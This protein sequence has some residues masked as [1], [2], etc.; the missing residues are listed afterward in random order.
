MTYGAGNKCKLLLL[1]GKGA[2]TL[3]LVGG[4]DR[5]LAVG[6]T[7]ETTAGGVSTWSTGT[8]LTADER[9]EGVTTTLGAAEGVTV[10]CMPG[11]V[12][13]VDGR[14]MGV[15]VTP[16]LKFSTVMLLALPGL[17][18]GSKGDGE[19]VGAKMPAVGLTVLAA[20]AEEV[21]AVM[22]LPVSDLDWL[23]AGKTSL[24]SSLPGGDCGWTAELLFVPLIGLRFPSTSDPTAKLDWPCTTTFSTSPL[25]AVSSSASS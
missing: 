12:L 7:E 18:P 1:A 13:T 15:A 5:T 22:L 6:R 3:L 4:G 20:V 17:A 9:G 21:F 24:I 16:P 10:C 14:R 8:A 19:T 25:G 11:T 2:I 23:S